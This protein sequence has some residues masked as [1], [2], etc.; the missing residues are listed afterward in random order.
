[1]NTRSTREYNLLAPAQLLRSWREQWPSN[2]DDLDLSATGEAGRVCYA[3]VDLLLISFFYRSTLLLLGPIQSLVQWVPEAPSAGI[4]RPERL[5]ELH[6]YIL[7][8][9]RI[10]EVKPAF[11][12][13]A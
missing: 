2:Q 1:M 3:G 12:N 9:L 4:K 5:A 8:G 11:R 10:C 13:V 6:L 7:P